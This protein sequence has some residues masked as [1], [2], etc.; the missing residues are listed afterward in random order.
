MFN[1]SVNIITEF[2]ENK[3]EEL[4]AEGQTLEGLKI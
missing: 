3:R 4:V 1:I 2:I